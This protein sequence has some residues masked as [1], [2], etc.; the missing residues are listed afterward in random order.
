MEAKLLKL[1]K[2]WDPAV[3]RLVL[4]A[5]NLEKPYLSRSSRLDQSLRADI[6][7]AVQE[8]AMRREARED[9]NP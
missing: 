9:G 7:K 1:T 3:S 2:G 5:L 4:R 6:E 8:E